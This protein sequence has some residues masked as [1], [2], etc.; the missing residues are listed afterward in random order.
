M[1]IVFF[2]N[3]FGFDLKVDDKIYFGGLLILRNLR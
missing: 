1:V 2:G 3:N